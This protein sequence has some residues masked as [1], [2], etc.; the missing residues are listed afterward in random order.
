MPN[1]KEDKNHLLF[2]LMTERLDFSLQLE[3]IKAGIGR[4][5]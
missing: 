5:A 4:R 3:N 2:I 1:K